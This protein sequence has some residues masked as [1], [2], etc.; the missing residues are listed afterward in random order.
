MSQILLISYHECFAIGPFFAVLS[1]EPMTFH[2]DRYGLY[3]SNT[4]NA[5]VFL[6]FAQIQLGSTQAPYT[7][8]SR[9]FKVNET[10]S[11]S[12][13]NFSLGVEEG[14]QS[15]KRPS[16]PDPSLD[17][18][19]TPLPCTSGQCLSCLLPGQEVPLK[20]TLQRAGASRLS[21]L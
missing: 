3:I 10:G 2:N 1:Q 19:L 9:M 18:A 7:K 16:P 11:H 15:S 21:Q 13:P 17:V 12:A 14:L 5:C 8:T 4:Q 6:C 20:K